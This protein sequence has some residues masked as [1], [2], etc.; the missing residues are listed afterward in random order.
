MKNVVRTGALLLSAVLPLAMAAQNTRAAPPGDV[1]ADA[2]REIDAANEAWIPALERQDAAAVAE[3]YSDDAVFV[4]PAG[5]S[6][7]GR[8]GVE[9]ITRTRFGV[10]R[11]VGGTIEQD[12]LVMQG[13]LVYEWGH[14]TLQVEQR[15]R[16]R[17]ESRGRYVTVWKRVPSGHWRIWRNLSLVD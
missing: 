10:S 17:A 5:E 14:A 6:V 12:G 16:T 9:K 15:D 4:T 13:S 11:V 8:A 3:P 7:I 2:R 1:P